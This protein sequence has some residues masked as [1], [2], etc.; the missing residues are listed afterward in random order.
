MSSNSLNANTSKTLVD[1]PYFNV[2]PKKEVLVPKSLD[3]K[4]LAIPSVPPVVDKLV[5][6]PVT[7]IPERPKVEQSLVSPIFKAPP[8]VASDMSK[9][10]VTSGRRIVVVIAVALLAILGIGISVYVF[11]SQSNFASNVRAVVN[12]IFGNKQ[13]EPADT[14]EVTPTPP[15]QIY[16]TSEEWR[17]QYFGVADCTE[18]ADVA[19]PDNDGLN[20]REEFDLG[21][22]PKKADTDADGLVDGDELKVFS[23]SPTEAHSAKNE[24]YTDADSLIGGWDCNKI[25]GQDALLSAE[26]LQA[27]SSKIKQFSLH[28]LTRTTLGN[29]ITLFEQTT[30]APAPEIQLPSGTDTSP[31]ASLERDVQ[32]LNTIKK[33]AEGL[34]AY[35]DALK[36]YPQQNNF[37]DMA[38]SIKPYNLV[39]T[40]VSDP[41]NVAPLVYGYELSEDGSSFALTYFSE[42][43]KQ[44]IRYSDTQ[45]K[46]DVEEQ[47]KQE[48][49]AQRMEDLN[50]IRSALLIYSATVTNQNQTFLFPEKSQYQAKIAPQY[51]QLVPHDPQTQLDYVYEVSMD[52]SSFSLKTMLEVPDTGT[53]GYMCDQEGCKAF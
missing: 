42:T 41:I 35:K 19:D 40:N 10:G 53:T 12:N 47:A 46:Q 39:A 31:E 33:I 28:D 44:L 26:R 14:T 50:K 43:Q 6:K 30:N 20:N 49:D 25:N 11:T 52:K 37:A 4:T 8:I 16:N 5:E 13:G 22:E 23:C 21:A 27:I 18:C 45:A 17:I 34:L 36:T 15:T 51:I 29:S 32:R 38:L 24:K 48:R 1:V 7:P 2:M 9:G 3:P